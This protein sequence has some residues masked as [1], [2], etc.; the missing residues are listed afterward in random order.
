MQVLVTW[1]PLAAGVPGKCNIYLGWL[2]GQPKIRDGMTNEEGKNGYCSPFWNFVS[3]L[4]TSQKTSDLSMRSEKA[5]LLCL[6]HNTP[7]VCSS[8][9]RAT[10]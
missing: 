2:C 4:L 3:V 8:V 5:S 10:L 7:R 9:P 6:V 1:S